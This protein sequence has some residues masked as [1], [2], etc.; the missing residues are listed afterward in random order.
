MRI[1]D[2]LPIKGY[3][4]LYTVDRIGNVY[5][6]LSNKSR[7]LGKLRTN[8]TYHGYAQVGLYDRDGVRKRFSVHRLVAET[9]IPNPYNLQQV[10]HINGN[11]LDNRVENL[12]WC[13]SSMNVKHAYDVGLA[14]K[15]SGELSGN[16]K[17][18][19]KDVR[20]IRSM[21]N[22][23]VKQDIIAK[24][25]NVDQATI[26]NIKLGKRWKGVY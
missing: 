21:L 4:G 20:I 9:F 13:T 12:E 17:L 19:V 6:E 7:R 3:E 1:E 18:T 5:S 15:R 26:S 24:K 2:R 23:S 14:K 16:H 22:K 10:N 25:F 8:V 11:K